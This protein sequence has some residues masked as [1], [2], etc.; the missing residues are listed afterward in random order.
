MDVSSSSVAIL[1]LNYGS[2]WF[3]FEIQSIYLHFVLHESFWSAGGKLTS[4]AP[5]PHRV[6]SRFFFVRS[7][8]VV[9]Y[10]EALDIDSG[11]GPDG[12]SSRVLKECARQLSLPIAKL[13]L[14]ILAQCFCLSIWIVKWL[15]P[16]HKRKQVSDPLKYRAINLSSQI[17]KVVEL[18]LKQWLSPRFGRFAF[19]EAQFAYRKEHGARNAVWYYALS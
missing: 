8:S 18:F 13:I 2:K 19:G 15:L 17:S 14:K 7:Q 6:W 5:T 1:P 4:T 16:L 12:L 11:T 10:I 9:C 3:F